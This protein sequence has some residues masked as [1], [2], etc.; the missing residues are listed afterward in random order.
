MFGNCARFARFEYSSGEVANYHSL[1]DRTFAL[2]LEDQIL[3]R[4]RSAMGLSDF[5]KECR[6][7]LAEEWLGKRIMLTL[8]TRRSA[9]RVREALAGDAERLGYRVEFLTADV[10]PA[11][12]LKAVKRIKA[13]GRDNSPCLVV[14]T[15]CVEAGVDIDLDFVVRDFGPLDSIIQ[16]AGRC[17]RN[18]RLERG[19]IEIVLLEDDEADQRPQFANQVYRDKVRLGATRIALGQSEFIDEEHVYPRAQ[20]YFKELPTRKDTGEKAV[21]DWAYWR[22]MDESVRVMLRGANLPQ[23]TFVVV[24][25]DAGLRTDLELASAVKGRW[26]KRRALRA[27]AGRIARVSVS[28]Y[29]RGHFDPKDFAEPFPSWAQGD[30][31]WFWLLRPGHYTPERGIEVGDN[32]GDDVWGIIV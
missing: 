4:H 28:V 17:N 21:N 32:I 2:D 25:R 11:D 16:I 12:R 20:V 24:E 30:D 15:Q 7:R 5:V 3:L 10:T 19:I 9:R 29:A 8:N 22:E 31:V 13:S 6:R 26:E 23:V 14:S 27:L 1:S 18:G